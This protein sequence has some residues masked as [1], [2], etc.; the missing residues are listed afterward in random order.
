MNFEYDVYVLTETNLDDSIKSSQIFPETYQVFRLDR[1][2]SNS[3]K[4]SG[5]GVLIAHSSELFAKEITIPGFDNLEQLCLKF[6]SNAFNLYVC[7]VYIPPGS[8]EVIYNNHVEY[9]EKLCE[10]IDTKDQLIVL[11]DYNLPH[12]QWSHNVDDDI[13]CPGNISNIKESTLVD[14]MLGLSL[15]QTNG[16]HNSNNR[17]LDLVFSDKVS[18]LKVLRC[19]PLLTN[20]IHHDALSILVN[21]IET[22]KFTPLQFKSFNFKKMD[23][24]AISNDFKSVDW[25]LVFSSDIIINNLFCG[26]NLDFLSNVNFSLYFKFFDFSMFDQQNPVEVL[27]YKFYFIVY[28]IIIKHV[29]WTR[30]NS[31]KFPPWFTKDLISLFHLKRKYSRKY[32]RSKSHDAYDK[33]SKCRADFKALNKLCYDIF[34]LN[35][36]SRIKED[37]KKFFSYVNYKN[38][39]SGF[40]SEMKYHDKHSDDPQ[41]ICNMFSEF[42]KSVYKTPDPDSNCSESEN[43][44]FLVNLC[45]LKFSECSVLECLKSLEESKGPGADLIPNSFLRTFCGELYHPISRIFNTSLAT[46]YFPKYWKLSKLIPIYKDGDK[47]DVAN[48]RGI[49]IISA[50]PK[51]FEKMVYNSLSNDILHHISPHQHGFTPGK[52]IVTNLVTFVSST[53]KWMEDGYQVDMVSTDFGKAFD[54]VNLLRLIEKLKELGFDGPL[55]SWFVSYL[56]GRLQFVKFFDCM[57]P[58]FEVMSGVPQGSHLGPL[59]F[60][61]FL[62]FV[63]DLLTDVYILIYADDT[64]LYRRIKSNCDCMELQEVLDQFVMWCIS[65]DLHLNV[66]KCKTITFTRK[67]SPIVFDYRILDQSVVRCTSL[68]DLGVL[69]DSE[70]TM[71][72]HVDHVVS[73]ARRML[74][75]IKR[76]SK[77]FEDVFVLRT[78]Y[79]TYVRPILEFASVVWSPYFEVHSQRIEAVQ[80]DFSRF[81]LRVLHWRDPLNLPS[82]EVRL[83]LLNLDSLVSRR[84]ASDVLFIHDVMSSKVRCPVLLSWINLNAC[85]VNLRTRNLLYVKTHRTCYGT[86]IPF[87][88]ALRSYNKYSHVIDVNDSRDSVKNK[89]KSVIC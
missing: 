80:R 31:N 74:G 51:M 23:A 1:N 19:D 61:L 16:H 68:K 76:F 25:S 81:A 21:N 73:K 47:S 64:K 27:L 20:E 44:N 59:M 82:Y 56:C 57:S 30:K 29:P 4:S 37:P 60:I 17:I 5:G 53:L 66:N 71:T 75:F 70:L 87:D 55:L 65:S 85:S 89:L 2:I 63:V 54:R 41:E 13:L 14:G 84:N 83:R 38:N 86:N 24:S 79:V 49:S 8:D 48:Y 11:G 26:L 36:G 32:Q 22:M 67:K 35:T 42:F 28:A 43:S 34:I 62:N 69:L 50:I 15:F 88:R 40:P 77:E 58:L 6:K 7:V 46:G 3:Y 45:N 52:S 33:F 12:I 18:N 9:L 10:Q 72:Y 78:L 39:T